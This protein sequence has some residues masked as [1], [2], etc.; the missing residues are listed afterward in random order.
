MYLLGARVLWIY[1]ARAV[2]D[3]RFER[4]ESLESLGLSASAA[5]QDDALDRWFL[6]EAPAANSGQGVEV[7]AALVDHLKAAR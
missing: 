7:R 5:L 6:R 1:P 2:P 4:I 3:T